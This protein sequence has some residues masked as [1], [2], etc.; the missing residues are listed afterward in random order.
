MRGFMLIACSGERERH[1]TRSR[2]QAQ[3]GQTYPRTGELKTSTVTTLFSP[4]SSGNWG[5]PAL[6]CSEPPCSVTALCK[7]LARTPG[8]PPGCGA[9]GPLAQSDGRDHCQLISELLQRVRAVTAGGTQVTCCRPRIVYDQN[10]EETFPVIPCETGM[11]KLQ[12][13]PQSAEAAAVVSF[14]PQFCVPVPTVAAPE[15]PHALN[16]SWHRTGTAG[17]GF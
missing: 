8:T 1:A 17:T 3:Q 12:K 5:G 13:F 9:P 6:C 2:R 14:S 7:H 11:E 4:L 16:E 15:L 10:Q